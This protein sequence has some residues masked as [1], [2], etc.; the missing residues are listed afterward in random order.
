MEVK[1]GYITSWRRAI[2]FTLIFC[3]VLFGLS[4]TLGANLIG[5]ALVSN[6]ISV[7][8]LLVCI[9]LFLL[10]LGDKFD[11]YEGKGVATITDGNFT[12][13]DRKR[14]IEVALSDI[15]KL[16][17][18]PIVLGQNDKNPLA[19]QLI[20][21]TGRKKRIIESERAR[22]QAYNEVDLHRLYIWIQENR[23]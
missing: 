17:I 22:G 11:R 14:H 21:Q 6:V 15:N 1:I 7:F 20:I 5:V 13:H 3:I 23:T 12:Y 10:V 8:V 19:Y 9:V 2:F 4:S 16:D 18:K